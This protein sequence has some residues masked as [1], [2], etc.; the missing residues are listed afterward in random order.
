MR[1]FVQEKNQ[2]TEP[3]NRSDES[4]GWVSDKSARVKKGLND[5]AQLNRLPPGSDIEAQAVTDQRAMPLS[6][7]GETDVSQD[8]NGG[9]VNKGF[10]RKPMRCTD[11]MYTREHNPVFYDT[12]S[13]DGH[14]GFVERGNVLD[15]D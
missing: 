10:T 13:V 9:A 1:G 15:R 7:G 11:E 6:M 5:S 2:V 8:Y 14:E 12:I 3:M 4:S